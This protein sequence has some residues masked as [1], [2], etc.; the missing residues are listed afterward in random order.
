MS[1][2]VPNDYQK[3]LA[4]PFRPLYG[5]E[6]ASQHPL[7]EKEFFSKCFVPACTNIPTTN[8]PVKTAFEID[9]SLQDLLDR[10]DE[11]KND[12]KAFESWLKRGQDSVYY[13]RG[14]AGTGKSVYLH[15]LKYRDEQIEP[16]SGRKWEIIDLADSSDEV[17]ILDMKIHIPDFH[18]IYYKVISSIIKSIDRYFFA[19]RGQEQ[20]IDHGKSSDRFI[21]I[22]NTYMQKCDPFYPD[23]KIR[24][25]FSNFPLSKDLST[26]EASEGCG[27]YLASTFISIL[28][29]IGKRD[30]LEFFLEVYVHLLVCID[31]EKRYIIAI[32]NVERIVGNDEIHNINIT[33]FS[34]SL[35][36]IHNSI[37]QNNVHLRSSYKFVVFMRNTS[38]R[39][40]TPQQINDIA[41]NTIDI[42]EWFDPETI[43]LKKIDWYKSCHDELQY[44]DEI[45][46]I[47]LDN[48]VDDNQIRG[49][50]TK[51][52]MLF[53]NNKRIIVHFIVRILSKESNRHYIDSYNSFRK[54]EKPCLSNSLS[55]FAARS[56]IYRLL[57]NELRQDDFFH[58]IMTEPESTNPPISNEIRV[59]S[60][61]TIGLGYARRILTI[62]YESQIENIGERYIPLGRVLCKLFNVE[63]EDL[64]RFFSNENQQTRKQIAG[65]LFAMNYYDG[66]KDNWLQFIDIQYSANALSSSKHLPDAN[67][68]YQFIEQD[69]ENL[70]LKITS[71]GKAYLFF[72]VPS[73]EY[74]ACKSL[75]SKTRVKI[76]GKYDTPP[77]LATI[78]DENQIISQ[79]LADMISIKTVSV[80]LIESLKCITKMSEEESYNP[81]LFPFR[82]SPHDFF[83]KHSNRIVNSHRGYIDNFIE[84]VGA[85]HQERAGKDELFKRHLALFITTLQNLRDFYTEFFSDNTSSIEDEVKK[86]LERKQVEKGLIR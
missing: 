78:P 11:I 45:Q 37:I 14:D 28:N 63:S 3:I 34:D 6:N 39:M 33:R 73:Y 76:F 81:N 62:L 23:E 54:H 57:L 64:G 61:G 27:R 79:K 70:K 52:K 60:Y 2:R 20:P 8:E 84:C 82:K 19:E 29:E 83:I 42:S 15:W 59:A 77:L 4:V 12:E 47:L 65:I 49:L 51:I 36:L 41:P 26:V 68:M 74:F 18:S 25:F 32:D 44:G 16:Q 31:R 22:H 72:I 7:T 85:I 10:E 55:Q 5:S 56:I 35:R 13:I 46:S 9:L 38:V 53:N 21:N 75:N 69:V 30:A 80:V 67:K 24:R 40:F 71:A 17:S 48:V 86:L 58:A 1:N 43:I 50:Y 66:R